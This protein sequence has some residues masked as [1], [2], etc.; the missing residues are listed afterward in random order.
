MRTLVFRIRLQDVEDGLLKYMYQ[1]SYVY[2]PCNPQATL[3]E[4]GIYHNFNTTSL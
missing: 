1:E 3:T 2:H 4:V